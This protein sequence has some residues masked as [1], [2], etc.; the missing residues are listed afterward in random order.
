MLITSDFFNNR[1]G[2]NISFLR[3]FPKRR[4]FHSTIKTLN[5]EKNRTRIPIGRGRF[6]IEDVNWDSVKD[7]LEIL[8]WIE[9]PIVYNEIPRG[10]TSADTTSQIGYEKRPRDGRDSKS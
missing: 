3:K 4:S 9:I 1:L 6:C 8:S 7:I 10:S 5:K 2:I